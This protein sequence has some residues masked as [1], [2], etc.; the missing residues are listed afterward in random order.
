MVITTPVPHRSA[1]AHR[2]RWGSKRSGCL[3]IECTDMA[4]VRSGPCPVRPVS[5]P[6]RARSS[7]GPYPYTPFRLAGAELVLSVAEYGLQEGLRPFVLRV[8]KHDLGCG[9]F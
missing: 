2:R 8:G 4:R 7:D 6:A 3:R 1:A 9:L 5:G